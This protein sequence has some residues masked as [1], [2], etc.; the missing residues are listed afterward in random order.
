MIGHPVA[1][2][3][4]RAKT[5]IHVFSWDNVKSHVMKFSAILTT[6]T[7]VVIDSE[8]GGGGGRSGSKCY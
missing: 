2:A 7:S 5:F 6:E 1:P 8:L 4:Q 3:V